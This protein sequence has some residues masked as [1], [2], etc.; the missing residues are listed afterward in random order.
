MQSRDKSSS[1]N[2]THSND[3]LLHPDNKAAAAQPALIPL[4]L[5][6]RNYRPAL[7]GFNLA[8]TS[9]TSANWE[10]LMELKPM[11]SQEPT[12]ED[13]S[14]K[15]KKT[16]N[17]LDDLRSGLDLFYQL[18]P[19]QNFLPNPVDSD[20]PLQ[21]KCI[22]D[23][24]LIDQLIKKEFGQSLQE[25][26]LTI[27]INTAPMIAQLCNDASYDART[28]AL[29][30]RRLPSLTLLR[31]A[32]LS[33]QYASLCHEKGEKQLAIYAINRA[34][35]F[36][37]SLVPQLDPVD[38]DQLRSLPNDIITLYRLQ[39]FKSMIRY[40]QLLICTADFSSLPNTYNMK[41][42]L[43]EHNA[44]HMILRKFLDDQKENLGNLV[45]TAQAYQR[46]W[47]LD[48]ARPHLEK[49]NSIAGILN[50]LLAMN[51]TPR[52]EVNVRV[53]K[54]RLEEMLQEP[55]LPTLSPLPPTPE[56]NPS[57]EAGQILP[58]SAHE[59]TAHS[60]F[61]PSQPQTY[62]MSSAS[63]QPLQEQVESPKQVGDWFRSKGELMAGF[64]PI[65]E[66]SLIDQELF[67][68]LDNDGLIDLGVAHEL[69]RELILKFRDEDYKTE[70]QPKM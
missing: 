29:H 57:L 25:E 58:P 40:N 48:A 64:S 23:L 9:I 41:K 54:K 68:E 67:V 3:Y 51:V 13:E 38:Y 39:S 43:G 4:S 61:F 15:F 34:F 19:W 60:R 56:I 37:N 14:S 27:P 65:F 55:F 42:R 70:L 7:D 30:D 31:L 66:R 50:K 11:T 36:I 6:A 28:Q 8:L 35:I 32:I 21:E 53:S 5:A 26:L 69:D 16:L 45:V 59:K 63:I 2:S 10:R 33:N 24:S 44:L 62:A 49:L 46:W 1:A 52:L 18:I 22:Q 20:E 12:L 17:I 47:E